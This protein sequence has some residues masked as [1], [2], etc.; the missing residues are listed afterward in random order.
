[1][2][3]KGHFLTL[4]SLKGLFILII[5]LHNTLAVTPLFS[6]IPGT[7]F[8]ILFGGLMGN[9]MFFILSGFLLSVGYRNRIQNQHITFQEFLLRRLKKLYPM[10]I[11]S[12]A[13]ALIIEIL[14]YG[15]SAINIERLIFAILLQG[16]SIGPSPYNRPT[17]FLS[18]LFVCYILFFFVTYFAKTNTH[19]I[20]HITI[21]VIVGY[22]LMVTNFDLPLLSA[23]CGT[24][25]MNFFLGCIL[26]EVYPRI[27]QKFHRWLQPLFLILIPTLAYLLLSF[28][29]ELIAGDIKICFA[30]VLCP[31][32]LYLSLVKG[33][34]SKILRQKCFIMLGE[35][36]SSIFFW[37]LVFY[38]AFCDVYAFFTQQGIQEKQ[39]LL[40]FALMV[41]FS[42]IMSKCIGRKRN[43][44]VQS[45]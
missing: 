36:S 45:V 27:S 4:T 11:I 5:A 41:V 15:V 33:P 10:Y 34:C 43:R 24:A 9:S 13:A 7:A 44:N 17:W 8:I 39:Y 20:S 25:Y 40:Y 1:M 3:Q 31:M 14:R 37:H 6:N 18:A 42:G 35:I 22:T 12:N 19:Y 38:F 16:G 30:F 28:G 21:G 32:I 2:E 26:A 23:G 29:V